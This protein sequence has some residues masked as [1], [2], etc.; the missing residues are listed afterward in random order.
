M[1]LNLVHKYD[2][3][4]NRK[5]VEFAVKYAETVFQRYKGKVK[6][7][8][9]FNEINALLS[10]PNPW[11]QGGLLF[12]DEENIAS[13]RLQAIHHQLLA[14]ALSVKIGHD[15]DPENKIGCMLLYPLCY[16]ESCNPYDS[17]LVREKLLPVYYCGDVQIRGKY[18][19]TCTRYMEKINGSFSK[20]ENDD[21]I[22]AEGTVDFIGLSYYF[23]NIEGEKEIKQVQGNVVWGG[24]NPYLKSTEWSWQIDPIGLRITL[25][26]LYDR[27]Q[28]PLFIVENGLGAKDEIEEDGSIQDDYRINYLS[29]HIREMIK[30][31]EIDRVDLIGYTS[32]GWIDLISAS[33]GEMSK[34]YGFVYVDCDDQG[35]G[36]LKR[37]KKKSFYWYKKV[38]ESNGK[39]L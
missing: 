4:R 13:T 6:Y 25:N 17:V 36:S 15:I 38:I 3:W 16:P 22:L 26:N 39:C 19:N 9:T 28:I 11:K 1:P 34:R 35:N 29:E 24:K 20:N 5:L 12:R 10:I 37:I 23:S 8:L 7:W 33:T 27:Y 2:S 31:V 32:W 18:T 30:A 21:R 14:S